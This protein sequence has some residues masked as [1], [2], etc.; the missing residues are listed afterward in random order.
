MKSLIVYYNED[1]EIENGIYN[2]I[3]EEKAVAEVGENNL[4]VYFTFTASGKS[5]AERKADLF[6]K[7]LLLTHAYSVACWAYSELADINEFFEKNGKRYGM[8][9]EFKE[10]AIC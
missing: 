3:T 1:G 10:N 5:Y 6:D 7:A 2:N 8:L 4:I 9:K